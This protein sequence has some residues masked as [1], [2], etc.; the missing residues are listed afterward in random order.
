MSKLEN[1]AFSTNTFFISTSLTG[2]NADGE[3]EKLGAS[4]FR[5]VI[6]CSTG[7]CPFV[8]NGYY[9]SNATQTLFHCHN[10]L[11]SI[12]ASSWSSATVS[13]EARLWKIFGT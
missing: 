6:S 9:F 12:F 2:S 5:R 3:F 11:Q 8:V 13:V 7:T 4:L 1:A 10:I